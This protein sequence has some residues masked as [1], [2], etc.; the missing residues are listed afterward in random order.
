[1]DI[2]HIISMQHWCIGPLDN[3]SHDPATFHKIILL[4]FHTHTHTMYCSVRVCTL[5]SAWTYYFQSVW[6]FVMFSWLCHEFN[7]H[8]SLVPLHIHII[9]K[10][11]YIYICNKYVCNVYINIS[12]CC[13]IDNLHSCVD[14]TWICYMHTM[15]VPFVYGDGNETHYS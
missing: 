15:Y 2:H 12:L 1:M 10:Y 9:L 6:F 5:C 11:V 13:V 7:W 4:K 8:L 14:T 3:D